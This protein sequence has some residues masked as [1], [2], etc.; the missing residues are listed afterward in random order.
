[1]GSVQ[2]LTSLY[3]EL[4]I[5]KKNEVEL[6]KNATTGKQKN[7]I[8]ESI[9]SAILIKKSAAV[10][11]ATPFHFVAKP[12]GLF[13]RFW[14]WITGE[15]KKTTLQLQQ[16]IREVEA[17]YKGIEINLGALVR[18]GTGELDPVAIQQLEAVR[19]IVNGIIKS[20]FGRKA[21]QIQPIDF[22]AKWKA[23][24][25]IEKAQKES[26]ASKT[27]PSPIQEALAARGRVAT[28][29]TAAPVEKEGMQKQAQPTITEAEALAAPTVIS[30]PTQETAPPQILQAEASLS[31]A[32]PT[33]AAQTE[34]AA[35]I[36]QE[37][38]QQEAL[39]ETTEPAIHSQQ[40]ISAPPEAAPAPEQVAQVEQVEQVEQV[41]LS[42][43]PEPVSVLMQD[44]QA[45]QG[46]AVALKTSFASAFSAE[47]EIDLLALHSRLETLEKQQLVLSTRLTSLEIPIEQRQPLQESLAGMLTDLAVNKTQLEALEKLKSSQDLEL[48]KVFH[49]KGLIDEINKLRSA[50]E[51]F[52][53]GALEANIELV[54][55]DR[56][57][58]AKAE[59]SIPV[60]EGNL[61]AIREGNEEIAQECTEQLGNFLVDL[62]EQPPQIQELSKPLFENI[63]LTEMD[64]K[65]FLLKNPDKVD[66]VK[67]LLVM[68]QAAPVIKSLVELQKQFGD[69][70]GEKAVE[71]AKQIGDQISSF[72]PDST[73][74]ERAQ[75]QMEEA[76][77]LLEKLTVPAAPPL[78]P[79][80]LS[81]MQAASEKPIKAAAQSPLK[82]RGE[83]ISSYKTLDDQLKES[84]GLR[85]GPLAEV[86]VGEKLQPEI[87]KH[88]AAIRQDADKMQRL[89]EYQSIMP[90]LGKLKTLTD[91]TKLPETVRSDFEALVSISNLL[92]RRD[93]IQGL[94]DSQNVE[95]SP[96]EPSLKNL[97]KSSDQRIALPSTL[98]EKP[99]L[100]IQEIR[101][102]LEDL[103]VALA[104]RQ[105]VIR[106]LDD[107]RQIRE[108]AQ[109]VNPLLKRT[110]NSIFTFAKPYIESMAQLKIPTFSDGQKFLEWAAKVKEQAKLLG[111]LNALSQSIPKELLDMEN[112][113]PKDFISL[114]L[115]QDTWK[116]GWEGFRIQVSQKG[117]SAEARDLEFLSEADCGHTFTTKAGKQVLQKGLWKPF[118]DKQTTLEE[119]TETTPSK[120]DH[121]PSAGY[122][123]ALSSMI[124]GFELGLHL[125]D[126]EPFKLFAAMAKEP[127]P[128]SFG[129]TE[130][131]PILNAIKG[132][133]TSW[134]NKIRDVEVRASAKAK[135]QVKPKAA[136]VEKLQ[137]PS[138][139][140]TL[141]REMAAKLEEM[142][143]KA[144]EGEKPGDDWET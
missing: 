118:F 80:E 142:R 133:I 121:L 53:T 89:Q 13:T 21:P 112:P 23:Q 74:I 128:R 138:S 104:E 85:R 30:A 77:P 17:K 65:E 16:T 26:L 96:A 136:A 40:A 117:K 60:L 78:A 114:V 2:S 73:W 6:I 33:S 31:E 50:D 44:V 123:N 83:K 99:G 120:E 87:F 54:K 86:E 42:P 82:K 110:S 4:E 32:L 94:E 38:V 100:D 76:K 70:T 20:E 34:E 108:A 66:D 135:P 75:M 125:T 59:G 12:T 56:E 131:T 113:T 5:T 93:V 22:N 81:A 140:P 103:P 134:N 8:I 37:Q 57:E 62:H 109:D 3:R 29:E 90:L 14:N 27:V 67:K 1:M 139:M 84:V 106:G 111:K 91:E 64:L 15:S 141:S 143:K 129:T 10:G 24:Q 48:A 68:K 92:S 19:E 124:D 88:L 102:A 7:K 127:K 55:Q 95:K 52:D 49:E 69:A 61:Q 9:S 132:N 119:T 137:G 25:K 39:P 45:A 116:A 46:E 51:Q 63:D 36:I 107:I 144:A 130:L 122:C 101:Q 35:Q 71:F 115:K 79:E 28:T 58:F 18:E 72:S 97:F 41:A 105:K 98:K 47:R 126:S 43:E 11:E